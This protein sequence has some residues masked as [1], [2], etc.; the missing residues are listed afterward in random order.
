MKSKKDFLFFGS[1]IFIQ[2]FSIIDGESLFM[3]DKLGKTVCDP[4]KFNFLAVRILLTHS[5]VCLVPKLPTLG[6]PII[7]QAMAAYGK[8]QVC[9]ESYQSKIEIF[10]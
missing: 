7:D 3:L 5:F 2:L 8:A 1:S 10:H 4:K 9:R 6:V